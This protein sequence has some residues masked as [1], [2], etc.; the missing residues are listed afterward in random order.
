MQFERL[1]VQTFLSYR[2]SVIQF[3]RILQ[4]INTG[5][6]LVQRSD[7]YRRILFAKSRTTQNYIQHNPNPY[8]QVYGQSITHKVQFFITSIFDF[9][10]SFRKIIQHA[11]KMV[12]NEKKFILV[13]YIS[14]S[15]SSEESADSGNLIHHTNSSQFSLLWQLQQEHLFKL[16]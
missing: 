5:I 4:Y 9:N 3:L 11:K 12:K 6:C 15:F 1:A 7:P 16:R 14:K 10:N 2:T 8:R 13:V